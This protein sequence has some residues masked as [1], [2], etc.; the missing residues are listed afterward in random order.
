AKYAPFVV[1]EDPSRPGF[2]VRDVALPDGLTSDHFADRSDV[3][4]E[5]DTFRRHLDKAAGDPALAL[6]DHY[7]QAYDLISSKEAQA[8]FDMGRE[9]ARASERYGRNGFGQRCLLA[10][11]LVEAGVPFVTVYDGG[12]DHHTRLFESL[13]K[14]LPEWDNSVSALIEDLAQRGLLD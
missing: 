10:R 12:W 1:A 11:R 6:D 13:K 2:K 5:V 3:R 8:A 14:R 7:K 4:H 9:P